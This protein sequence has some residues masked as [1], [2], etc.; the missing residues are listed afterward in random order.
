MSLLFC[1]QSKSNTM[2][3]PA[4]FLF[5]NINLYFF[6]ALEV[7]LAF[8]PHPPFIIFSYLLQAPN[9]WNVFRFP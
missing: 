1:Q 9:N 4:K 8:L 6:A 5:Q 2:F 7:K 3:N